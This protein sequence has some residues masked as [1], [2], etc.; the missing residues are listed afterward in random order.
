MG[1]ATQP[2]PS[3]C[4]N[5]AK[6]GGGDLR[7]SFLLTKIHILPEIYKSKFLIILGLT[8]NRKKGDTKTEGDKAV[9]S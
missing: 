7:L 5:A 6:E 9:M 3:I 2:C 4:R 8:V 1:D